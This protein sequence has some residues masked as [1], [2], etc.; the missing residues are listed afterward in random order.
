ME[1]QNWIV[2]IGA[3][4]ERLTQTKILSLSEKGTRQEFKCHTMWCLNEGGLG[5]VFLF[6]S[7]QSKSR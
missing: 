7:W 6:Y 2:V 3:A 1:S 4:C 5:L